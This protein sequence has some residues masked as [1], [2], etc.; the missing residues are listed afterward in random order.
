MK[1]TNPL[2]KVNIGDCEKI[3]QENFNDWGKTAIWIKK[4]WQINFYVSDY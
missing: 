4:N 3:T 1:E 2:R